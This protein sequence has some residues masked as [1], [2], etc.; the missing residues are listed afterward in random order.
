MSLDDLDSI[1]VN[2][3]VDGL[4]TIAMA[5]ECIIETP[6]IYSAEDV[7]HAQSYR[8]NYAHLLVNG[9]VELRM[10]EDFKYVANIVAK[11][12]QHRLHSMYDG[13]FLSAA[14]T[15]AVGAALKSWLACVSSIVAGAF[16]KGMQYVLDKKAQNDLCKSA[17]AV[18]RMSDMYWMAA[19]DK[20]HRKSY[21]V[22]A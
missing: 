15:G 2:L 14:S 3:A 22:A 21:E 1:A 10:R 7:R 19:S 4:E 18:Y 11:K 17:D 6:L 5:S 8:S 9:H 13:L 16:F 12:S 20:L